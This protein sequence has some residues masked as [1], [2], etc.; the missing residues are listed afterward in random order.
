MLFLKSSLS[1]SAHSVAWSWLS[2][3]HR[4]SSRTAA[5]HSHRR[6]RLGTGVGRVYLH[7]GAACRS[8]L[9]HLCRIL[10]SVSLLR[11][12]HPV[13]RA[14]ALS[15]VDLQYRRLLLVGLTCLRCFRWWL[16]LLRSSSSGK[17]R[18]WACSHSLYN[19]LLGHPLAM[20]L[21]EI[22]LHSICQLLGQSLTAQASDA[23]QLDQQ[24][25]R[26]RRCQH[27]VLALQEACNYEDQRQR[28]E[29][30]RAVR[31]QRERTVQRQVEQRT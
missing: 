31:H 10:A 14:R 7:A 8:W 3:G 22:H 30:D 23:L 29:V 19:L 25:L 9:R 18:C 20:R 4:R 15:G 21:A 16:A 11:P 28:C 27:R 26:R 12:R 1:A 5:T 13:R 2:V 17:S 6:L 24:P